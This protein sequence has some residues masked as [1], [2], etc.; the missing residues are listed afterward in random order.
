MERKCTVFIP[1]E[2]WQKALADVAYLVTIDPAYAPYL[3]Y[4]ENQIAIARRAD[5][6]ERARRI[7]E[8]AS[9]A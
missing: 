4:V 3:D 5:P 6:I 9:N 1:V 7:L 2:R 8:K